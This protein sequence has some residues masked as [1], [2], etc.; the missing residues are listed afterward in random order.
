MAL[1]GTGIWSAHLRYGDPGQTAEAAAELDELGYSAI[2]VPDVGGDVL[3]SVENLLGVTTNIEVAT[4]ILNIWMHTPAEVA[5]RRASWTEAWQRRFTL[6]LGVSHAPLIDQREAGLYNKPYSK[7]VEYLDGLD[8]APEPFPAEARVLAALKPRMLRLARDRASGA[9]PYFVPSE[10]VAHAREILG[11]DATIAVELAVVRDTDPSSAR[12]TAR[13][14]TA[15]YATLPNYTNNLRDFGFGDDDFTDAGSDRLVDA[16]V[17]WGDDD[18]IAA[19]VAAMRDAG[20]DHVCVQVIRP[21][22]DVPRDDWR[23]LA[24]ALLG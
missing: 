10:H 19:R 21:D 22:E 1:H 23:A 24:P 12:A 8:A 4:G 17:A 11:P 5:A 3:G 14:H 7:M 18:A 13:R 16:I 20:A 6:G 15:M 9:H 2:W